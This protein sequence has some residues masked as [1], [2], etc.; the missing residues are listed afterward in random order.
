MTTVTLLLGLGLI[1][2]IAEVLIPSMGMLGLGA[3]VCVIGA[4]AWAFS[5]SVGYGVQVL[6]LAGVLVP[7]AMVLALKVLP[8]SPL[9]KRLTA[10][11][12]SFEDG[13]AVDERDEEL[14]GRTGVVEAKL[15]PIGVARIDGRRVDVTSRGEMIETGAEVRVLEAS[16]NRVVDARVEAE[17]NQA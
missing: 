11:G 3:A 9:T 7:I 14:V 5:I 10:G 8:H 6:L 13:R 2:I 12:F 1:L 15:R 4:V 17:Q 16:A